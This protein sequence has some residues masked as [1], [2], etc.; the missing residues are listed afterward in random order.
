MKVGITGLVAST[1]LALVASAD[2]APRHTVKSGESLWLIAETYKCPVDDLRAANNV[3]EDNTIYPGDRLEL[4]EACSERPEGPKTLTRSDEPRPDRPDAGPVDP[5]LNAVTTEE[6]R[7]DGNH[8]SNKIQ[9]AL[10]RYRV[11]RGDTLI[12]LARKYGTSVLAIQAQNEL[13]GDLI[14]IGQ[15]LEIP[16]HSRSVIESEAILNAIR[17]LSGQSVGGTSGG[18]LSNGTVLPDEPTYYRRR[19]HRAFGAAHT[20]DYVRRAARLVKLRHPKV[21]KLAIGDLSAKSGGK[22]SQHASHQ[23][24]RD[25][26]LGFYF[27][28]KPRG[29]PESFITATA[30][31]LDFAATWTLLKALADTADETGGV[32]MMFLNYNVQKLIYD[33]ARERGISRGVLKWIFQYPRGRS[34]RSGLI[35][36]EPGHMG[37]VHVRFKCPPNDP[38]CR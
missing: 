16:A 3:G 35:R 14:M 10:V 29:Y 22:I 9:S 18:R 30:T 20:V 12:E 26:D 11:A 17:I 19:P 27:S 36:H 37:H 21:H 8:Q 28:R 32:Q 2:A 23:S 15:T 33:W 31:N 7:Q 25:V 4:P 38:L 13:P 24:G 6:P 5:S 34:A 1:V